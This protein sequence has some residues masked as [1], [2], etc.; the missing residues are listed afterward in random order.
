MV[1]QWWANGKAMVGYGRTMVRQ[2]YDMVGNNGKQ[3]LLMLCLGLLLLLLFVVGVGEAM[4]V[5][6]KKSKANGGHL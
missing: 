2:W 1:G 6:G 5:N 3:C 4:V